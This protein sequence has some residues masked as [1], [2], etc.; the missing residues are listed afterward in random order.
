MRKLLILGGV[1]IFVAGFYLAILYMKSKSF[2]ATN[3]AERTPQE[4]AQD[5]QRVKELNAELKPLEALQ[6]LKNYEGM[7][8]TNSA[9]S[10]QWLGLF[11]QA[12]QQVGNAYQLA[13]L[14]QYYPEEFN[15]YEKASI[16]AGEALLHMSQEKSLEAMRQAWK[17]RETLKE[18]WFL[19]DVDRLIAL[20]QNQPAV[21]LLKSE[22]FEGKKDTPRLIRLA[23][24]TVN[25]DPR[26]AW[27]YF[28]EAHDKDPANP[29]IISY[30]ARLLEATGKNALAL[31]EYVAAIHLDPQ[32]LKL[33][34]QLAEFYIRHRYYPQA[35]QV[36]VQSFSHP[37]NASIWLKV[38]FWSHVA[39]PVSFDWSTRE[40]T[41][42]PLEPLIAYLINLKAGQFWNDAAY[43][44]VENSQRYLDE[45][46]AT[47]WL[48]LLEYLKQGQESPAEALVQAN[49]FN[50]HAWNPHINTLL[51]RVFAYQKTGALSIA[52]NLWEEV[53]PKV[54]E[55]KP[56]ETPAAAHPKTS[57]AEQPAASDKAP[58][59]NSQESPSSPAKPPTAPA[60]LS[61][62][63]FAAPQTGLVTFYDQVEQL[64]QAAQNSAVAAPI[65][66]DVHALLKS[67]EIFSAIFLSEGW[68][69]AAL[70]LNKMD[71]LPADFPAWVA[72][73]M[74]QALRNNRNL[75]T[76]LAF[77]SK[78]KPTPE[79]NVLI[80]EL[81]I[82]SHDPDG[83]LKQLEKYAKENSELGA[84][85]AWLTSLIYI[86]KKAFAK[87][88]E[89][90]Q[91]NK[92]LA[93]SIMGKEVLA[94]IAFGENKT[95]ETIEIYHSIEDKS[96]EAK[97]FFARQAF[98]DKDWNKARTL[99]LELLRQYPT[100]T[101]LWENLQKI[102]AAEAN[103]K[104]TQDATSPAK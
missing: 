89:V 92:L 7:M 4:Q 32:S 20:G 31:A 72:Y 77:A 57:P 50:S 94:R 65:P 36:W 53:L 5:L 21:D 27:E 10:K 24:L 23:L 75:A 91:A 3:Q 69:E 79:L 71:V 102:N 35:L 55:E 33:R 90:V 52:P 37:N 86:D 19:L 44:N 2:H 98:A 99:T 9:L 47:Y 104:E 67:P 64:A 41:K 45:Q 88:E 22:T 87:A 85:A 82:A 81:L 14:Y 97:S 48:R 8:S 49:I 54:V 40:I 103:Q 101:A 84:R 38:L 25:E 100:E 51:K 28:T 93:Q 58:K 68:W 6:I 78:Q 1:L 46:Q 16:L 18:D 83:G 39:V 63:P 74:T 43:A 80:G 56:G 59:H 73:G 76:A 13:I 70:Q 17:G 30:R 11:I 95:D 34:D 29:A 12:N 15:N 60:R 61:S 42:G 62:E 66:D 96:P 26:K